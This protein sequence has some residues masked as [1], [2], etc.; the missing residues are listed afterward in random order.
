MPLEILYIAVLLLVTIVWMVLLKRPVYEGM[1]VS[2]IVLLTVSWRWENFFTYVNAA[3]SQSIM[4]VVFAFI[5]FS[6]VM[7]QTRVIDSCTSIIISIFGRFRGGAGY[8][9]VLAN[10]FLG[11][12][13]GG[14]PQNVVLV[15]SITLP[16][17]KKSG[18]PDEVS[19]NTAAFDSLMGNY[20]PPSPAYAAIFGIYIAFCNTNGYTAVSSTQLWGMM[21]AIAAV[22]V[23]FRMAT[24]FIAC[25]RRNVCAIP[26]EQLPRFRE[27]L[28]TGWKALFLPLIIAAPF[29]L[30]ML[31]GNFISSQIG[32]TGLSAVSSSLLLFLP[33]FASFFV[34]F[35]GQNKVSIKQ[36]AKG[37]ASS[38]NEMIT[39]GVLV[40][41]S[42]MIG[43]VLQVGEIGAYVASLDLNIVALALI[44][45]L[46][47][48]VISMMIASV[49]IVIFFG[50][51]ILVVMTAAG[52]NPVLVA[53]VIPLICG[54][55]AGT[56]PPS[57]PCLYLGSNIVGGNV[58]SI[59][60]TS[61]WWVL[62]QFAFVEILFLVICLI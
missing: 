39:I 18:I 49:V 12:L 31:L 60:K 25:R 34:L 17:M 61:V 10:S 58:G 32:E 28:K 44:I 36:L 11:A 43:N 2:F 3:L 42:L 54:G 13:S 38:A 41:F 21:W 33:G 22:M 56:I 16:A 35:L 59:M 27:A 29:V 5:A 30:E 48:T 40:L 23:I 46:L 20:I 45:P 15:G 19:V 50:M 37:F 47:T 52:A 51:V 7:K 57:S 53:A 24:I 62:A 14:G 1:L 55:L 26:K 8:A 6:V 9:D 4:Y